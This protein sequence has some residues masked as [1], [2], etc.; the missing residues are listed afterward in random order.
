MNNKKR[1]KECVDCFWCVQFC[2]HPIKV[3]CSL[4][5]DSPEIKLNDKA[6]KDFHRWDATK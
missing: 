3:A 4:K 2:E 6:C 1:R 5:P